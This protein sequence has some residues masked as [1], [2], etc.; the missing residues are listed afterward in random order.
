MSPMRRYS[1]HG[2]ATK[3]CSYC[4]FRRAGN[5]TTQRIGCAQII[6]SGAFHPLSLI[7]G[8]LRKQPAS[9]AAHL[10]QET[11]EWG[12]LSESKRFGELDFQNTSPKA[13][14]T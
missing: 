2:S 8:G 9:A 6:R 5:E 1:E 11:L 13:W 3:E 10:E 7:A 14:R 12:E 4:R